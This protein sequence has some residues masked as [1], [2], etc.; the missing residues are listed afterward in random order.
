MDLSELA[1]WTIR[2]KLMAIPGVANVAIWGQRDRQF[3]VLVD[4]ERL[5]AVGVTLDQVNKAVTDAV[6]VAGGGFVDTPNQRIAVR[7]R[8]AIETTSD[9][10]NTV[11]AF[12][13]GAPLRLA[14]ESGR[15]PDRQPA[16]DRRRRARRRPGLLLIVE[17]QP[18]GNTLDVTRNVEKALATLDLKNK[19]VEVDPTIFRPATFIERSIANLGHAMLVGCGLVIV[20]LV[21]FLY[22]WRTALISLTAIP[23][24]LVAAGVVLRAMGTTIN[25]MVLAGLV[26]AMGE[27]VDDAIID[28]ENI[29]RRLR[30]NRAEGDRRSAVRRGPGGVAGGPQRAWSTPP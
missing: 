23:L 22:D 9:L 7:H 1:K 17:K 19:G 14:G 29:V 3:Q 6:M 4:P 26:I 18:Q 2:P 13:N 24:S 30:Q 20:I 12:R 10:R 15:G 28:V 16:A 25:T 8:S 27:V 21:G 5:R 11:V